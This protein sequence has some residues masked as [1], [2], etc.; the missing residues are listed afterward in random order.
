MMA[1]ML[2][3]VAKTMIPCALGISLFY[4]FNMGYEDTWATILIYP[5]GVVGF[6]YLSSYAFGTE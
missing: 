3:D 6:T 4:I 1:N 2:F 5:F